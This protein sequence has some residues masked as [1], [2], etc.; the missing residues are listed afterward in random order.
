MGAFSYS[1]AVGAVMAILKAALEPDVLVVPPSDPPPLG[2]P[3][4]ADDAEPPERWCRIANLVPA[5]P[6]GGHG[7]SSGDDG[8]H[9]VVVVTV[10]VGCSQRLHRDE[11]LRIEQD[12]DAVAAALRGAAADAGGQAVVLH[13][14]T[15]AALPEGGAHE[16][17]R[18]FVVTANGRA[19]RG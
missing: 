18:L 14:A 16:R 5:R 17:H 7:R 1:L 3:Q 9:T 10:T 4:N 19:T 12:A 2:D 11:P 15:A 6:P 13:A 8:D